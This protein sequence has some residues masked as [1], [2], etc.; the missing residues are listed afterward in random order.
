[1]FFPSAKDRKGMLAVACHSI[2]THVVSTLSPVQIVG[3]QLSWGK[4]LPPPLG[5]DDNIVVFS[6]KGLRMKNDS[7]S[8]YPAY[9]LITLKLVR[10][11]R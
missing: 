11:I 7:E 6:E 10:P 2:P 3:N 9:M 5:E 8:I 1:M 4:I